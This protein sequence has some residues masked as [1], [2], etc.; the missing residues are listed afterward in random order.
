MMS[1]ILLPLAALGLL[2]ACEMKIG[3]E[4]EAAGN[5]SAEPVTEASVQGKAKEGE[6]SIN[7]PGFD[8]K[9]SIPAFVADRAN[10]EDNQ[11]MVYPGAKLSG[12][13]VEG[14][15]QG[16]GDSAVELRFTSADPADR[17]AAWYRDPARANI[18]V[19]SAG[20]QGDDYVIRGTRK[21]DSGPFTVRLSP[22]GGGTDMRLT[23]VDRS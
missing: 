18:A 15:R 13:H 14:R 6:F 8:M 9:F 21:D 16:E 1:R 22:R 20:R 17:I 12:L 10:V 19:A 7:A 3:N 2:A 11:E 23:L 5:A 4:D